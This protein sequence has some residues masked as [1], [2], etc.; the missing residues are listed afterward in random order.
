MCEK[1]AKVQIYNDNN[2]AM[3]C[4]LQELLP[5]YLEL[6]AP[7]SKELDLIT[8]KF[9][10]RLNTL[11]QA[12][13]I[14]GVLKSEACLI[15]VIWD[16]KEK[17]IDAVAFLKFINEQCKTIKGRIQI[18]VVHKLK[19]TLMSLM[20]NFDNVQS[21]YLNYVGEICIL[22]KILGNSN[23]HLINFEYPLPNG[24]SIDYEFSSYDS[25]HLVEV[26]NV[27]F[28]AEK[29]ASRQDL[30]TFFSSRAE[31]KVNHKL[32]NIALDSGIMVTFAEVIWGD[33]I[34]LNPYIDYF[35]ERNLYNGLLAPLMF[36]GQVT[37]PTNGM[38]IYG[39]FTAVE[40]LE[41]YQRYIASQ[42]NTK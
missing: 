12:V 26:S 17:A 34:E 22:A 27:H 36:V 21:R 37:D 9:E 19:H 4:Y 30:E 2:A 38:I 41:K 24:K 3:F 29:I 42:D 14:R 25:S 28:K 39:F 13:E 40:Y 15:D 1:R 16:A 31:K 23:W 11:K 5:D 7:T 6:L 33:L 18:S 8:T 32:K 35:K 10:E 20:V